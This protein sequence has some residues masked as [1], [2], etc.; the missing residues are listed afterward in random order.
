[1]SLL[2]LQ[3]APNTRHINLSPTPPRKRA[4]HQPLHEFRQAVMVCAVELRFLWQH[5][6]QAAVG[7]AERMV[8]EAGEQVVQRLVVQADGG[9]TK[10]AAAPAAAQ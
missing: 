2:T 4:P 6:G 9:P 10:R 1:M 5:A 7:F 8:G 3:L